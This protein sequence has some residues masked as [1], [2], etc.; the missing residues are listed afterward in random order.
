MTEAREAARRKAEELHRKQALE[1]LQRFKRKSQAEVKEANKESGAD[2]KENIPTK[3]KEENKKLSAAKGSETD[4]ASAK[5]AESKK[6]RDGLNFQGR[7]EAGRMSA[8]EV[9]DGVGPGPSYYSLASTAR[10]E[11]C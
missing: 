3:Y 9:E 10:R 11:S 6:A 2:D 7:L 8:L 4:S 5:E 1:E